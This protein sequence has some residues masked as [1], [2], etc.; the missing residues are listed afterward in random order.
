MPSGSRTGDDCQRQPRLEAHT[1]AQGGQP[2]PVCGPKGRDI[3]GSQDGLG[4]AG[5]GLRGQRGTEA[6]AKA[7]QGR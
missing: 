6:L 5:Q 4:A 7:K 2:R 3:A 1:A